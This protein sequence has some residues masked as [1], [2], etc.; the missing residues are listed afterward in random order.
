L[1]T[2]ES[3]HITVMQTTPE[4]WS[5]IQATNWEGNRQLSG[6][7]AG[8]VIDEALVQ[9][10][11]ARLRN[12][13][14]FYGCIETTIWNTTQHQTADQ[15]A[16]LIGKPLHNVEVIILDKAGY[17]SPEG[18]TGD[19]YIGGACLPEG[20]F[21][22]NASTRAYFKTIK[23]PDGTTKKLFRTGDK[24]AWHPGGLIEYRGSKQNVITISGH[25]IDLTEIEQIIESM[26]NVHRSALLAK[27]APHYTTQLI[28]YV[29]PEAGS[30]ITPQDVTTFLRKHLPEFAMPTDICCV[31]TLP[32]NSFGA[33]ERTMLPA[34]KQIIKGRLPLPQNPQTPLEKQIAK[35]WCELLDK[36]KVYAGDNFFDLGGHSLLALAFITSFE[37]L[38][39]H[40]LP[41]QVL[42]DSSLSELAASLTPSTP[43]NPQKGTRTITGSDSIFKRPRKRNG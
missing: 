6:F 42:I 19:L 41:L 11:T 13:W 29:M 25:R 43:T 26:A 30:L 21:R 7:I 38:T 10:L 17:P 1:G 14:C 36:D 20:Y 34:P 2:I 22:D 27:P 32:L 24:A 28:A 12:L 40:Q 37:E 9:F 35:L 18:C 15:P 8:G 23:L 4:V 33:I 16:G 5:R 39:G 3:Q 31:T